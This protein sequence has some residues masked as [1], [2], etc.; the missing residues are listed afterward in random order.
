LFN[1]NFYPTDDKTIFK[2][3]QG[4]N[5]SDKKVL[6]P[7]AGKG[8]ILDY[9]SNLLMGTSGK[10]DF[11]K[12]L[13]CLEIEPELQSIL[14]GKGYNLLGSDF[15][16]FRPEINFDIILMNPPFDCAVKHFLKAYEISNGA[17]I[18][19]LL[20][21][22]TIDN[23]NTKEKKLLAEILQKEGIEPMDMGQCFIGS[24]RSTYVEV[25]MITIPEKERRPKFDFN[26]EGKK[27]GEKLFSIDDIQ[28]T[29][30]ESVDVVE[31]LVHR[32]TKVKETAA[33]ILQL[34]KELEFYSSGLYGVGISTLSSCLKD[35]S[36]DDAYD[37]FNNAVRA[38]AWKKI[39]NQAKLQDL[40]TSGVRKDFNDDQERQG[41]MAF[42]TENIEGL[43]LSLCSSV[44]R[45]KERCILEAFEI[46]TN[47]HKDNKISIDGELAGA[48][49]T[50][51]HWKV[52]KRVILPYGCSGD[53]KW[54]YNYLHMNWQI[55]EKLHD[56]EKALCFVAG[57]KF[58]DIE[59]NTIYYKCEKTYEKKLR[60]RNEY[61]KEIS[62][63]F[64]SQVTLTYHDWHDSEF[65]RFKAFKKG[66]MHLE[67]KSKEL[68]EKFN[69][70]ACKGKNW[71]PADWG[72][73]TT[74]GKGQAHPKAKAHKVRVNK[75]PGKDGVRVKSSF[76]HDITGDLTAL[77]I[78]DLVN[79]FNVPDGNNS[80]K[81][82]KLVL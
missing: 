58:S 33:K 20:N 21:K 68:Y 63:Y 6:E 69:L 61:G 22:R 1:K 56:V 81:Q 78:L 57:K 17:E 5:F 27:Y 15:L 53:G 40:M 14:T 50:N 55:G 77:N 31:S 34:N 8:N 32:Y 19:C 36:Y 3:V 67:F 46:L 29:Q 43:I 42:T 2:M 18:R 24:E 38:G 71:I 54:G 11:K 62:Y 64:D 39:I 59:K 82:L 65:F 66:T 23:A 70:A 44:D 45:I 16:E 9:I 73:S 10:T 60:T 37:L 25:V 35:N 52:N 47:F 79:K 49:K 26:F 13:Y 41:Y 28:N 72:H 48:W 74:Q 51:D 12:N 76:N 7:E 4:L 80:E 30:L 75:E